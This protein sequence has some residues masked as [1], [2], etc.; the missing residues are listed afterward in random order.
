MTDLVKRLNMVDA[1]MHQMTLVIVAREA[2]DRIEQ[3]EEIMIYVLGT[4][5]ADHPAKKVI[6]AALGE[7][8]NGTGRQ[9]WDIIAAAIGPDSPD[10]VIVPREP[11]QDDLTL[12]YMWAYKM[13]EKKYKS[14]IEQ[15]EAALDDVAIHLPRAEWH[16]LKDE[17]L[18]TIGE[19]KDAD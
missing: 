2:A 5:G 14:R 12:V 3:L 17:T 9:G 4:I 8:Q 13:A 1:T 11:T 6:R 19:K 7:R 18:I 15:L 16:Y 10:M